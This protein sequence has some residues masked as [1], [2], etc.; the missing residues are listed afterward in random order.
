MIEIKR[1]WA[2]KGLVEGNGKVNKGKGM[3]VREA[4]QELIEKLEK[5]YLEGKGQRPKGMV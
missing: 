3:S 5:E 1:T 4:A 2:D